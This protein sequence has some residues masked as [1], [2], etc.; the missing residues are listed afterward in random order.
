MGRFRD[1]VPARGVD[2]YGWMWGWSWRARR[3]I[4]SVYCFVGFRWTAL[5]VQY[6]EGMNSRVVG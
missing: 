5:A 4:H 3:I 2:M 1:F 6:D